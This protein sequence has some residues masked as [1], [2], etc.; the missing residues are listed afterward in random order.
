MFFF[1]P[2]WELTLF[3]WINQDW[4]NPVFDVLMPLASDATTLWIL[5]IVLIGIGLAKRR[6]TLSV[7]LGLGLCMGISDAACNLLKDTAGRV[8]PHHSIPHTW[9]QS[10]GQWFQLP[11]DFTPTKLT[12]S[13]FPSAHAANAAVAGM[14]LFAASRRKAVWLIPLVIGYSRIYLGKHFPTDVIAGWAV[15]TAV[16]A[17]LIPIYPALFSRLFSR[18]IR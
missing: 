14:V 5:S 15:G 1:T 3:S 13:S 7:A 9:H 2:E 10:E 12:G 17:I 8:R 6:L 4:R 16:A 11:A 18:W